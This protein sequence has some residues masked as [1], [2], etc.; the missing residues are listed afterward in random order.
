ME[1]WVT[2]VACLGGFCWHR[3]RVAV[4]HLFKAGAKGCADEIEISFGMSSGEEAGEAFLDMDALFA[5]VEM[6]ETGQ[7]RFAGNREV[8]PGGVS[9]DRRGMREVSE[10]A[11]QIAHESGGFGCDAVLKGRTSCFQV[12]HAGAYCSQS[13]GMAHEG[14]GVEGDTSFGEGCVAILPH[15][16]VERVHEFG[17][18]GEHSH[19]EASGNHLAVGSEIGLDAEDSLQAAGMG[20]EAGDHFVEDERGAVVLGDATDFAQKFDGAKFGMAALDGLDQNGSDF[21][22]AL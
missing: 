1:A 8:E 3:K 15:A 12:V 17:T 4:A 18:A 6:K 16:P 7:E 22:G 11:L 13:Q 21:T 14:S 2:G 20:A 5:Q 19:G 9:L 10:H